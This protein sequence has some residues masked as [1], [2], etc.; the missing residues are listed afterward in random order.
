MISEI[1]DFP[2]ATAV[3]DRQ[4]LSPSTA[5]ILSNVNA[6]FSAPATTS[7]LPFARAVSRFLAKGG[8][9]YLRAGEGLIRSQLQS[10]SPNATPAEIAILLETGLSPMVFVDSIGLHSFGPQLRAILREIDAHSLER[11]FC[12]VF[13]VDSAVDLHNCHNLHY[14]AVTDRHSLVPGARPH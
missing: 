9:S 7:P 12:V 10:F 1:L 11:T 2:S 8:T 5:F 6:D 14:S 4:V 13:P 3:K